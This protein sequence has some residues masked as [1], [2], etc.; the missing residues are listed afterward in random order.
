[1]GYHWTIES[2]VCEPDL[3]GHE[4]A[5]LVDAQFLAAA[6]SVEIC[7]SQAQARVRLL[8]DQ[9]GYR[10]SESIKL[11]IFGEY[12]IEQINVPCGGGSWLC[13]SKRSI[14]NKGGVYDTHNIDHSCQQSFLMAVWVWWAGYVESSISD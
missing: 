7:E 11:L 8:A 4:F 14:S 6:R 2:W 10:V 13:L 1:M 12:G 9:A 3:H 5:I